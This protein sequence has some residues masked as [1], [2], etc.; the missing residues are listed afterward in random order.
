MGKKE[1]REKGS[2]SRGLWRGLLFLF[3]DFALLMTKSKE[4]REN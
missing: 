3:V 1:R 2:K 4:R